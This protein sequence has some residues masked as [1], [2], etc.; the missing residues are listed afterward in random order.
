M[1]TGSMASVVDTTRMALACA[2]T[3]RKASQREHTYQLALFERGGA[4]DRIGASYD[5]A[6]QHKPSREHCRHRVV[7]VIPEHIHISYIYI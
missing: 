6:L 1:S 5:G 4:G 2:T 7:V 3:Y